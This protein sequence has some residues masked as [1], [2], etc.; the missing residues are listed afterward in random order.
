MTRECEV[1][2]EW[3][4][5]VQTQM[6]MVCVNFTNNKYLLNPSASGDLTNEK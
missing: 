2:K 5:K 3:Y 1:Y 6:R 4:R